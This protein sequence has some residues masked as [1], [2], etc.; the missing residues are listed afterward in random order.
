V[1]AIAYRIL[2][3]IL[4]FQCVFCLTVSYLCF[5]YFHYFYF[6]FLQVQSQRDWLF[7]Q[8]QTMTQHKVRFILCMHLSS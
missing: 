7:I 3:F 6:C 8:I 1:G 5:L 2:I 4:I